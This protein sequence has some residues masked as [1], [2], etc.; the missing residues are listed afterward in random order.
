MYL[1]SAT[2]ESI[3]RALPTSLTFFFFLVALLAVNVRLQ[4]SVL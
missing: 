3:L 4:V 1:Y 2:L